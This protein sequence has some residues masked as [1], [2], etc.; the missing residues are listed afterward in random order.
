MQMDELCKAFASVRLDSNI[1]ILMI[2]VI[3]ILDIF[4]WN[5]QKHTV[6][7]QKFLYS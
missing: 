1:L 6:Y 3:D 7:G 5:R 2:K 4:T